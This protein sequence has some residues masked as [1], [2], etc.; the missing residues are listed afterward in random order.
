MRH[1]LLPVLA[2]AALGACADAGDPKIDITDGV[3]VT[4]AGVAPSAL[5][6]TLRNV[7]A[8]DDT[9]L[10]V[11]PDLAEGVMLHETTQDAEGRVQMRHL[12]AI[13]VPGNATV[14]LERGGLHVMI[15]RLDTNVVRGDS[16][17]VTFRFARAGAITLPLPV[18]DFADVDARRPGGR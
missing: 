8:I 15:G 9:L 17:S 13:P 5:Y 2:A 18:I 12:E 11:L 14:A 10:A 3:V 1:V 7:R 16:L 6:A 4:G